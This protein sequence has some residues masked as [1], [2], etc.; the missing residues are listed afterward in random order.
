MQRDSPD[1]FYAYQQFV[2]HASDFPGS[3]LTDEIEFVYGV[4]ETEDG[5]PDEFDRVVGSIVEQSDL[6]HSVPAFHARSTGIG[7]GAEG[8]AVA[9]QIIGGAT[10]LAAA[11]V[12]WLEFGKHALRF[13]IRLREGRGWPPVL[14]LGAVKLFCAVHLERHLGSIDGAVLVY[15]GD[16]GGGLQHDLG[17][18]GDDVF[19]VLF[20]RGPD[21][22]LYLIDSRGQLL[23][24]S[25]GQQFGHSELLDGSWGGED[26]NEYYP[27]LIL[28][29]E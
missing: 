12:T 18:T 16:V 11:V 7:R 21:I 15:A 9:F 22:Y 6:D 8:I 4:P 2:E 23:V 20:A 27:P 10:V 25:P 17:Y 1:P 24:F 28:D 19:L 5:T 26:V 13:W 29:D 14:S 3:R